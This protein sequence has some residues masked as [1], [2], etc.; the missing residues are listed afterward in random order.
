MKKVEK[1]IKL[2]KHLFFYYKGELPE[3]EKLKLDSMLAKDEELSNWYKQFIEEEGFQKYLNNRKHIDIKTKWDLHLINRRKRIISRTLYTMSGW[4][5]AV[6][7][8][9]M[10]S[11]W[12]YNTV[13]NVQ[14]VPVPLSHIKPGSTKAEL[15]TDGGQRYVLTELK[16]G[17]L[18]EEGAEI[19]HNEKQISYQSNA[20]QKAEKELAPVHTIV[21][22]RGGKHQLNLADGT[23]VWLNCQ[24]KLQYPVWFSD[25]LR[26]VSLAGEAYFKVMHNKEKP[27]YVI[28]NGVRLQVLGTEFNVQAYEDE[29]SIKTTLV[30]GKVNVCLTEGSREQVILKPGEQAVAKDNKLVVNVVDVEHYTAWK[31]GWF[32]FK[33]EPL[34]D[35]FRRLGRW[36]DFNVFFYNESVKAYPF[37]GTIQREEKIEEVLKLLE[38]TQRVKFEINEKNILVKSK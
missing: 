27:F 32:V 17:V 21:V 38:R 15:I 19:Q 22:P 6:I 18:K 29:T 20:A 2:A 4:A 23:K 36:Y 14:T 30:N 26:E 28:I 16:P 34:K 5:A 31:E 35:M 37:T 8:L 1:D 12:L 11:W 9:V 24:S 3:E 13:T 7:V 10:T 25:T 33:D